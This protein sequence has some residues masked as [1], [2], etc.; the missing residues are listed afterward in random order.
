MNAKMGFLKFPE[1]AFW[2]K[3]VAGKSHHAGLCHC[4]RILKW[5]IEINLIFSSENRA[6]LRLLKHIVSRERKLFLPWNSWVRL[7]ASLHSIF[8]FTAIKFPNRE[9]STLCKTQWFRNTN[10]F[11]I[12]LPFTAARILTETR[13]NNIFRRGTSSA[14]VKSRR[15]P[16]G[17]RYPC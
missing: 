14:Q 17:S 12:S 13:T 4:P 10:K 7:V 16:Q 3:F 9:C 2:Q 1:G 11:S 5:P 15:L 8:P 6:K